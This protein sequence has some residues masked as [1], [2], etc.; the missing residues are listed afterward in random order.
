MA[1]IPADIGLEI[2]ETALR[3]RI[4]GRPLQVVAEIGSTNDA[5]MEAAR[6]GEPEGFAILADRQTA[7]RGRR[8]RSWVSPAGVGVYASVLLRPQQ[9]PARIPLLTLVGGLAVAG[10]I[11]EKARPRVA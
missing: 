8:G 1:M 7:G 6:G 10:G 4:I 9:L 5:V 2:I 3:A 11:E